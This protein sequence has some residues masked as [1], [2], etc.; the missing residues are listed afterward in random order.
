ML[1]LIND[2]LDLSKIEAGKSVLNEEDIDVSKVLGLCLTL[3]KERASDAGIHIECDAVANLPAL[4]VDGRKFKQILINLLSN[5][6]KFTPYGGRVTI[7]TRTHPEDGYVFQVTDTGIGIAHADLPLAFSPFQQIDSALNRKYDGTGLGLPLAKAL[8][9][10]HGGFLDLQ[11]EI[12]VGT[13]VTV[14]FPADRIILV[15]TTGT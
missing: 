9:E 14:C 6:I 10:L 5:A 2:I 1:E 15:A 12:D 4:H 11:S 8:V 3:V 13:T 7:K